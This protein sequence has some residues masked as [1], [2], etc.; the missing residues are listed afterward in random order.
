MAISVLAGAVG[1]A[2]LILATLWWRSAQP[3]L[4]RSGPNNS[5]FVWAGD[6]SN[7]SDSGC[8]SGSAGDAGCSDG[9]GGGGD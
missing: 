3:R 4:R 5:S 9:G 7:G 1:V 6:G 2:L 8:D